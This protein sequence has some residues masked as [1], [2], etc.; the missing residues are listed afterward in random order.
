[1][2]TTINPKAMAAAGNYLF[3]G[4]VHTIPNIDAFNLTTGAKDISMTS[5]NPN[6]Y[7]GNDVDSMYGVGAYQKANGDY[8]ITKDNYN[9]NSV[10]IHTLTTGAPTQVAAP[11]F[12]PAAGSYT[13]AQSVTISTTT[14]GASIRYTTD[15]VTTP[16]STVGTLYTGPVTI[17]ATT[18]LQ[19]IAYKSGLTDSTVTSGTYTINSSGG[20]PSPWLTQD[21]GAVGIAGSATY[22]GGTFTVVGSGTDI[23]GT[24]D[25]FR[26][27]YQTGGTACTITARVVSMTN[28]NSGAKAG[29]MIR[30]SLATGSTEASTTLTP[31]NGVTW[32]NRSTTNGTTA[33]GRTAGLTV[34]YWVRV[35]RSGN[36]FTGYRS[37]DGVTWTQQGTAT[38]TMGS[39]VYLG[40]AVTSR[41]GSATCTATFDNITVSP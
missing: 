25:Q 27:V 37:P 41:N 21:V 31:A 40:L 19:A 39:S 13:T 3:V 14:S 20:L 6:V 34:P 35:V 5:S 1:L 2:D 7:V 26:F 28:S 17:S 32:Q 16:T 36:T 12:S 22:S 11:S 24:A 23:N 9:G 18:T 38:I 4:Y 30:E 29:V 15:G 8:V 33:G 10:V